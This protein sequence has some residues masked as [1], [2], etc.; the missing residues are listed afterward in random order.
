MT[1]RELPFS[2]RQAVEN[3]ELG[4][5]LAADCLE[6]ALVISKDKEGAIRALML[7]YGEWVHLREKGKEVL[8]KA[9]YSPEQISRFRYQYYE[10]NRAVLPL[11]KSDPKPTAADD[12]AK[13]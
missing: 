12:A 11:K 8:E 3:C 10:E 7:A 13:G 5:D 1:Y 6:A 2:M 9:G 4:T